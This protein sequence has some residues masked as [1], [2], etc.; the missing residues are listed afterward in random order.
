[1]AKHDNDALAT[2]WGELPELLGAAHPDFVEP[3]FT[4]ARRIW[5]HLH[6]G[7]FEGAHDI[8]DAAEVFLKKKMYE[9][10]GMPIENKL[11][12]TLYE[13]PLA[14]RVAGIMAKAGV[15][16]VRDLLG[17][18]KSELM[19]IGYVNERTLSLLIEAVTKIGITNVIQRKVGKKASRKKTKAGSV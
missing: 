8:V 12:L 15:Y 1:M 3:A 11:E 6:K 5:I 14:T 18:K 16:T 2:I 13:I 7:D 9:F 19:E 4:F 17:L 10:D